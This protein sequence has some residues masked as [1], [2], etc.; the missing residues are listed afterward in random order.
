M[1]FSSIV[2]HKKLVRA[3]RLGYASWQAELL[4]INKDERILKT[5]EDVKNDERWLHV[6]DMRM[7]KWM[8]VVTRMDS[9]ITEH[10]RGS[11][12]H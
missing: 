9:I 6:E 7:S 1:H 2:K 8:C 3:V 12:W 4:F 10:V 5:K 11:V